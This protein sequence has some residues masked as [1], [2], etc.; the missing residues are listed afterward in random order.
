MSGAVIRIPLAAA[1]FAA[2]WALMKRSRWSP[3][4]RDL[5]GFWG[6]Q[7]VVLF[8]VLGANIYAFGVGGGTVREVSMWVLMPV[9]AFLAGIL[10]AE[11]KSDWRWLAV[12]FPALTM[13]VQLTH[14]PIH[15]WYF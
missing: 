3:T 13:I 10:F 5:Y 1:A 7:V 12:A 14:R 2:G 8:G 4:L 9:A 15:G 11:I 6:I